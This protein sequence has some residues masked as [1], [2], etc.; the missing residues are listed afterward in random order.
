MKYVKSHIE[1][2]EYIVLYYTSLLEHNFFILGLMIIFLA[3]KLVTSY[4]TINIQF[5]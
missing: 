2:Y 5:Y 3:V 4:Y 1:V